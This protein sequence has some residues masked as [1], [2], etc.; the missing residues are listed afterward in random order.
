MEKQVIHIYGA[1]GS[2]TSTLGRAISEAWNFSFLDVDDY[3]WLPTDPK[4]TVKREV[5]QRLALLR[6]DIAASEQVVVSG[7]LTDWGDELIPMF[8]L[9]VR[10]ETSTAV[11]IARLKAREAEEFGARILPGGDMYRQ[12]QD[13]LQWAAQYDTGD[14]HIR[15]KAKHDQWQKLLPC[16]QIVL[17]GADPLAKNL[18]LVKRELQVVEP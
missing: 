2:G 10:L 5:S 9:A 11:R 7:S 6:R 14:I 16:R 1:S 8:T 18:E 13:F 17:N 4:Y 12:H 15:S 3:F